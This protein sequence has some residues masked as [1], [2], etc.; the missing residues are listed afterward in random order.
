[1][2]MDVSINRL[3]SINIVIFSSISSLGFILYFLLLAKASLILLR[4]MVV[5]HIL[6]SFLFP[7]HF[8]LKASLEVREFFFTD[9]KGVGTSK[10]KKKNRRRK[11][12][13]KNTSS[14]HAIETTHKKVST[15]ILL[16]PFFIFSGVNETRRMHYIKFVK[17][18][19]NFL[20][21]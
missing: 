14:N 13:Q 18:Y 8:L 3:M 6:L 1:M 16:F 12:Q 7:F 21:S 17:S 2:P 10:N 5:K 19:Y 4:N 15:A 9:S 20:L 11:D